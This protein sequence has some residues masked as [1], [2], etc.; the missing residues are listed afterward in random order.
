MKYL[1]ESTTT[2]AGHPQE[3]TFREVERG[4]YEYYLMNGT[5]DNAAKKVNHE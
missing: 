5:T 3:R 1:I 2:T 4:M